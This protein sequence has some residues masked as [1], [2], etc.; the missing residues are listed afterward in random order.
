MIAYNYPYPRPSWLHDLRVWVVLSAKCWLA[1]G[2]LMGWSAGCYVG[3]WVAA[4]A[5]L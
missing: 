5:V 2:L 4:K 3:L 1:A